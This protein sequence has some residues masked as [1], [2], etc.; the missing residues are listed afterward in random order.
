[1]ANE[2]RPINA[3]EEDREA[4]GSRVME[5]EK[6]KEEK[7]K[8]EGVDCGGRRGRGERHGGSGVVV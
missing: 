4:K 2:L 3:T 1:M 7:G 6:G 8:G 5:E